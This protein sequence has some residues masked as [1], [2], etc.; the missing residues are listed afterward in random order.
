MGAVPGAQGRQDI[1]ASRFAVAPAI[2]GALDDPAWTGSPLNLG[3]WISYNPLRGDTGPER[4]EVRVGYD[5]RFIYI[6]FRCFSDDPTRIR[7]TFTKRD[8]A[9]SDDWVGLSLDSTGAGQSAYHFMI[10]PS[11]IQMDAVNTTAAGERFE[12]DF[13]W[14]SAGT[15][16]ADGYAVEIALPLETIRFSAAP[17]V[18]MGILFW[19]HV[20]RSGVSYSWP[21][22]PPGQWVFDRH[23]PLVFAGL[24]P[25]RLFEL[26]PSAT[27]PLSQR[28]ANANRWNDVEGKADV[29]LSVKYGVTSEITLDGTLNPDF[30]QVESDAFQVQVNQRFPTFFSEKRPFFM[31]G[32]GLFNMAGSGGDSTMRSPVHTRRIVNPLW[33]T[34]VTGTVGRLSFGVLEGLDESPDDIGNRGSSIANKDKL[35]SIGRATY[36][37]G[38]SN[39]VG[40]LVT[41]T[42]HAGRHNRASGGDVS[43]KPTAAQGL[44]GMYLFSQ[45]GG[46]SDGAMHGSAAQLSYSYDTRRMLVSTLVEHYDKDFQMDT[47]FYSRTGFT[48][49]YVYSEVNFYPEK[50]KR[51]GLIRVHPLVIARYGRDRT[52]G[53]IEGFL[54]VGASFN[55]TRQGFL[56]IQHGEGYEPWEGRRFRSGEPA[57]AFGSVQLFRWL[58]VGAH[59]VRAAWA[60]FYDPVDPYQGRSTRGG[61]DI[62]W[63]PNEHFNQSVSYS[64][65]RFERADTGAPVF[66]VDI[67]NTKSV[68]QFDKHLLVRFIEQWDSS[69]GELLSDF[70][71]SYEFVP[72]TVFHAGYGSVFERQ[73]FEDGQP[74]TRTGQYVTVRRGLFFKASYLRRF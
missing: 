33:G 62:T 34:K 42:K 8:N 3:P 46:G 29:G 67:V 28:R 9:F 68:Y 54:F 24:A 44:T 69:R 12:S 58:N 59:L 43:W 22:L 40:A 19:R 38:G 50:A 72:G 27:A 21:D 57:S 13:I 51:I 64:A 61:F 18:T 73:G 56:R 63:Q 2:D 37:L 31:E 35:F 30:S 47:A 53:G 10:N 74:G 11:G 70:L 1:R 39:Y 48:S 17:E 6:G 66:D 23:A 36:G 65:E 55:F 25:R 20:S 41:D 15:R 49:A 26:L 45:T 71:A 16:T 5:D 60:T 52:H 4:T 32:L 14:F 7:T